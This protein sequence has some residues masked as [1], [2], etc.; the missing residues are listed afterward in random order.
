LVLCFHFS[1]LFL[2]FFVLQRGEIRLE[3]GK[4]SVTSEEMRRWGA[5]SRLRSPRTPFLDDQ[6]HKYE[7]PTCPRSP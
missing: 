7:M 3:L 4:Y 6:G 5:L 2:L 1:R